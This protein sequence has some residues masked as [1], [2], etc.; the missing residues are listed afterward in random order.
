MEILLES[1][2]LKKED[3]NSS[4]DSGFS[5]AGVWSK[6]TFGW[7]NPLFAKGRVEKVELKD[8]PSIPHSETAESF[9]LLFEE[10]VREQNMVTLSL[11]QVIAY[12]IWKSLAINAVFAGTSLSL[13]HLYFFLISVLGENLPGCW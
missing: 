5:N 3:D 7:L 11:K 13:S 4:K 8:I 10:S 6:L 2:L 1:P 12:S 9:S